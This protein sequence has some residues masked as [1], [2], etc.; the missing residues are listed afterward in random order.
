MSDFDNTDRGALFKNQDKTDANPAWA[1]YEGS[2]NV[3]GKDYY[4]SAWLK[5]AKSG[6]KYMSLS[7][8]EKLSRKEAADSAP[9]Q[10]AAPPVDDFDTDGL[11]F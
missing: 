4:L 2:I 6:V 9:V 11:P 1:D 5:T 8:K 3:G 7:V 10:Q